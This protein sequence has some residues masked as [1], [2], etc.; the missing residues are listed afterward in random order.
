MFKRNYKILIED[1]I[2]DINKINN[3]ILN[4]N[5]EDF[6][7]DDKTKDA[8]IKNLIEIGEA[9]NHIPDDIREK[10]SNHIPK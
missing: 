6:I 2:Q 7:N 1:I 3:Y 10:H 4:M 9:A 5:Y 8:V